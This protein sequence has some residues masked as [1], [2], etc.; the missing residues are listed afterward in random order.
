MG[1]ITPDTPEWD[2]R[3]VLSSLPNPPRENT[4]TPIPFFHLL[5]RLKS[6]KREGW[7]QAGLSHHGESI[8]DHMYRMSIMTMFCPPSLSTRISIPRCIEMALV[9][10][11][12]ECLVGDIT[13]LNTDITKTEKAR[14]EEA[15]MLYITGPLLGSIPGGGGSSSTGAAGRMMGLFREY[16]DNETLEARF[17][18]DVDKLEM[19]LQTIEYERDLG[20]DLDEFYHVL[21]RITLPEMREWAEVLIQ[22]RKDIAAERNNHHAIITSRVNTK[23]AVTNINQPTQI[24]SASS[25]TKQ[26][27]T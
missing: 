9:H 13:P 2:P 16:E 25:L 1:S 3:T 11:M 7:Q 27:S 5:S 22:E 10:D 17:V 15:T 20:R 18:H 23:R 19:V 12:A 21:G 8:A 24:N 4:S 6:T 14:R 26:R